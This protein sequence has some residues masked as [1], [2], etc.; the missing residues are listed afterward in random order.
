MRTLL[1][2]LTL[3]GA[4]AMAQTQ[5][6]P[7]PSPPIVPV[8]RQPPAAASRAMRHELHAHERKLRIEE[9][10]EDRADA[11]KRRKAYERTLRRTRH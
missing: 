3:S 6:P 2:I 5:P 10:A 7:E 1:L 9:Q 4:A 8:A 11:E